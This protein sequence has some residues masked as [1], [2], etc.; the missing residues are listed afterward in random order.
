MSVATIK[1]SRPMGLL[2]V[3]VGMELEVVVMVWGDVR[4]QLPVRGCDDPM[5]KNY[6]KS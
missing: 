6:L 4:M 5:K 1:L 2:V 3:E